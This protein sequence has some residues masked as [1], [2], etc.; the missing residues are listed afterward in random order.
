MLASRLI[1][2][3]K[4]PIGTKMT[5]KQPLPLLAVG[6][7]LLVRAGLLVRW[8]GFGA[9]TRRRF[10]RGVRVGVG[11]GLELGLGLGLGGGVVTAGAGA[12]ADVTGV[13]GGEYVVGAGAGE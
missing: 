10:A 11:V 6:V 7:G 5:N 8:L 12:G 2:P 1:R 9:T 3:D 13:G 4:A